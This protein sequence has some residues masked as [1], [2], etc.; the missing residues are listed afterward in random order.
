[1]IKP[2]LRALKRVWI[3]NFVRRV[4]Y[5]TSYFNSKYGQILSWGIQSNEDTNYTYH[6]TESNIDYLAQLL[7]HIL[8][9]DHA[10]IRGYI[11]ELEHN[12]VLRQ[13]IQVGIAQSGLS[14]FADQDIRYGKRL[15]WYALVRA[16][17]PKIVVETGVD[18]GLG[19]VVLAAALLKNKAE[20]FPGQFYG[21]DINPEAG[22]LLTG[23][24]QTVGKILYGDSIE[25]L[26]KMT[27]KIDF[28]INDSDHSADYEYREYQ[29]IKDKLSDN[30]IIIG[31]NAH[32][33]DKL[34]R[35]SIE[36]DRD[37]LYFQEQPKNHWYPG[38]GN[39][40]SFI[41]R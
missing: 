25:T 31:D 39:G 4:V 30:A 14:R 26:S 37:F 12:Q 27:E 18:K 19:S 38:A 8:Q 28:F 23:E 5:A 41:R 36:N 24:Y 34:S 7:A 9:S 2:I 29:T 21:T 10:T 17:K 15:G 13:H 40:F 6:L 1:M 22:Y 33:T 32:V 35:F 16:M 11:A 20:G 3:L